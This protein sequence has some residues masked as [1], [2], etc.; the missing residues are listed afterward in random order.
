MQK[1]A[2]TR[3]FSFL[4]NIIVCL[5]AVAVIMTK[6]DW[7]GKHDVLAFLFWT[8]PLA[9]GFATSGQTIVNLFRSASP[10]PRIFFLAVVAWLVSYGWTRCVA[11]LLHSW[12]NSFSLP[13]LYLWIGGS[14]VQLAFLDWRLPPADKRTELAQIVLGILF[15]PLTLLFTLLVMYLISFISSSFSKPDAETFLIPEGYRGKAIVI[16]DQPEGQAP[17]TESGRR[18]Y[19]IPKSGVLFTQFKSDPAIVDQEFDYVSSGGQR[20]KLAVQDLPEG[21]N[22]QA[23]QKPGSDSIAVFGAGAT[24]AISGASGTITFSEFSVG[25]AR[26][27]KAFPRVNFHYVDSL[28]TLGK[29]K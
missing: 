10:V 20:K 5:I 24:R 17:E 8:V 2:V 11:L 16:F 28:R 29:Q 18:L 25:T 26:E 22:W 27:V 4:L 12:I 21:S 9:A 23:P 6:K 3:L 1:P 7:L 19:R 15:L 14:V 13:V